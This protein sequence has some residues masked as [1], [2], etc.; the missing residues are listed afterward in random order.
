MKTSRP[1]SK[2][3]GTT[4]HGVIF[5]DVDLLLLPHLGL[6]SRRP[7]F[8]FNG[9]HYTVARSRSELL[10]PRCS[11][12]VSTVCATTDTC[13]ALCKPVATRVD[14]RILLQHGRTIQ[15][16]S[17]VGRPPRASLHSN[18][19]Q[20]AGPTADGPIQPGRLGRAPC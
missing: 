1:L 9:R 2:N 19:E 17:A 3:S 14:A 10:S 16:K 15:C 18:T 13:L 7:C 11:D 20:P 12:A 6:L 4:S 8:Q 5:L